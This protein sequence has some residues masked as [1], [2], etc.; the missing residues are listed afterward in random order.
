MTVYCLYTSFWCLFD[1]SSV[2][3]PEHIVEVYDVSDGIAEKFRV[4]NF[5]IKKLNQSHLTAV[6]GQLIQSLRHAK[7]MRPDRVHECILASYF[8]NIFR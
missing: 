2:D 8:L 7:K 1:V 3:F 6:A 4:C 5:F